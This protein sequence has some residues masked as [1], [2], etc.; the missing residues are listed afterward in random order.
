MNDLDNPQMG[1][2]CEQP[3]VQS[4][5]PRAEMLTVC[6]DCPCLNNDV[7]YGSECKLGFSC[8]LRWTVGGKLI[9]GSS[10]CELVNIE[11]KTKILKK[12]REAAVQLRGSR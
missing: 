12:P 8:E 3:K 2:M 4:G 7:D 6:D 5:K 10:N 9:N 11:T 1:E